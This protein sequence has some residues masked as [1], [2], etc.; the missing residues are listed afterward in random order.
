MMPNGGSFGMGGGSWI[1]PVLLTL[2]V[3]T[4]IIVIVK[5]YRN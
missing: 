1:L 5:K 4:L 3:V 2:V